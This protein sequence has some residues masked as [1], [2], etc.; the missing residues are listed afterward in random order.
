[1]LHHMCEIYFHIL[2]CVG[3][4]HECDKRMDI[5]AFSNNVL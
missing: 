1:M 2:N 3:V 4:A 5:T